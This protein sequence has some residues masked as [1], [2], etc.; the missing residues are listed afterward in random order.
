MPRYTV[1]DADSYGRAVGSH[2]LEYRALF[3]P[4]DVGNASTMTGYLQAGAPT[5]SA[6]RGFTERRL[7]GPAARRGR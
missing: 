6:T 7:P 4:G 2:M 3:I 5:S 1:R